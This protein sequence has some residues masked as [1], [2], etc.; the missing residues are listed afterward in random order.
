MSDQDFENQIFYEDCLTGMRNRLP[1]ACVDLTVTSPPYDNLRNYHSQFNFQGIAQEL[2][3]VTKEG[4]VIVWVVNDSTIKGSES[5]T[6]FKQAI[7]FVEECGFRLHDTMI[8]EKANPAPVP[9]PDRYQPKFEYMFVFSKSSPKTVNIIQEPCKYAGHETPFS[10]FRPGGGP[11]V[12]KHKKAPIKETKPRGNIWSYK[13]GVREQADRIAFKHPA[14]FPN[15]LA[16]DHI[17]SWSNPGDIIL[18]PFMGAGTTAKIAKSLGR[19]FVG[20]EINPEYKP[21]IDKRLGLI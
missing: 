12:A 14:T 16:H 7:Y 3:R 5:L 20:F 21:I 8:Y 1:D 9:Q 6:S 13:V 10:T 11:K 19:N 4:G 15:E 2:F 17:I 18:D